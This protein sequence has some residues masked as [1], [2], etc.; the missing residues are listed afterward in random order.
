MCTVFPTMFQSVLWVNKT[1]VPAHAFGLQSKL[2]RHTKWIQ[3]HTISYTQFVQCVLAIDCFFFFKN[4][5][6]F[7]SF[8]FDP[9]KEEYKYKTSI[10]FVRIAMYI[11][12]ELASFEC[13]CF[14]TIIRDKTRRRSK[15]SVAKKKTSRNDT[16]FSIFPSILQ[17]PASNLTI[18]A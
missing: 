4:I 13:A 1:F 18:S 8:C 10:C 16:R 17:F 9:K 5:F 3:C 6:F 15:N 2:H 14:V 11:Y 7:F 12:M